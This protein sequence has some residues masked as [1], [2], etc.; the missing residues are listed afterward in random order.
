MRSKILVTRKDTIVN[1]TLAKV[2][3]YLDISISDATE[4]I[5][6]EM[7]DTIIYDEETLRLRALDESRE[8]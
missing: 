7:L 2:A 4:A 8:S 1:E 6:V 3:V 5:D